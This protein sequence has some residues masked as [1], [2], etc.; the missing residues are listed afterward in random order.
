MKLNYLM[1]T[2]IVLGENCIFTNRALLGDLGKKALMVT[3]RNSAKQNG[4]GA[5][6]V[7]AL[8]TNGQSYYLYDKV[9]SNPTVDCAFDAAA[10]AQ[11]EHCDFVLVIGGGSPMDAGKAAAAIAVSPVEKSAFFSTTFTKA[12]P[13]AAVPTTAGTGS[14]VTPY[15]ILTNDGAQTK[16]SI[17]SP[18]IFPR[19]AFLDPA[20][21]KDMGSATTINTALD[22]LSH[23]IE[24]MLTIRA[25]V[26]TDP[27]A[28]AG[29]TAFA[30]C[31][32]AL[33]AGTPDLAV[34]E[35]L[36][37]A[38]TLG[39]MVISNTGTTAVHAMGYRLT[40]FKNIDHGRANG[41]LLGKFLRFVAE[42]EKAIGGNRIGEIL[43]AMGLENLDE[44]EAI[45]DALLGQREKIS[46]EELENYAEASINAKNI[47]NTGIRPNKAELLSILKGSVDLRNGVFGL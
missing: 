18:A 22:A 9:M 31:V 30:E 20:Y 1:P 29:I 2:K 35:K 7:K 23:S 21:M 46:N 33:K 17:A 6:A 44:F 12:L 38:S 32:P 11:R 10:L 45:M 14:E 43:G 27:M 25:S 28:K 8:E 40:Y 15:A 13:I 37:W 26:F 47:T 3:G 19:Y 36:L 41:L 5:D 39:G 42:K 4:S 34:R 24:G 16:T